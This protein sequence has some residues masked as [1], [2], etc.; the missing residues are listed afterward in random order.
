M[1]GKLR[2]EETVRHP[3]RLQNKGLFSVQRFKL[4]GMVPDSG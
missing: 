4:P 2:N 3:L 1:L